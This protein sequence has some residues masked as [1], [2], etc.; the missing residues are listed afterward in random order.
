MSGNDKK[1]QSRPKTDRKQIPNAKKFLPGQSGNPDGRPPKLL[2][3]VNDEL[4]AKG[5][6]PVKP[7]QIAEA[8]E[9]LL[10]LPIEEIQILEA[11][12]DIPYFLRIICKRLTSGET[13]VEALDKLLDRAIGKP[14]QAVDHTTNGKEIKAEIV[15]N[16]PI[17][18]MIKNGD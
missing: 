5:F 11:K 12:P 2:R 10:N 4:R 14:K 7:S 3:N 18:P 17:S 9:T 16:L 8:F 13:D 6:E 15:Y 1:S